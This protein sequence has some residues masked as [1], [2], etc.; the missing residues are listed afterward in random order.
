MGCKVQDLVHEGVVSLEEGASVRRAAELMAARGLGSL[1][2]TR[3][4]EVC[5]LFTEHDLLVRVVGAGK[6]PARVTLAEVCSRDLVSIAYD[7]SCRDAVRKMQAHVCR[8]LLVYRG[9]RLVGLV[10]LTD[11]AH[12]MANSP[13]GKDLLVNALGALTLVAAIGVVALLLFQLPSMIDLVEH[14]TI[15]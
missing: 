8:R 13:G 10:K 15:H 7:S 4:G 9:Q 2:V 11:I 6:D 12:A 1:V 3:Q 14:V 5:G